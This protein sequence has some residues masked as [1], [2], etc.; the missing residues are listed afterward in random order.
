[1]EKSVAI[2]KQKRKKIEDAFGSEPTWD[3]EPDANKLRNA[4]NWYN[5]HHGRDGGYTFLKQY[6]KDT[7]YP[8][9]DHVK[10]IP[11][12][13]ISTTVFWISKLLTR[14]LPL[15][16]E[17]VDWFEAQVKELQNIEV[18]KRESVVEKNKPSVQD[19]MRELSHELIGELEEEIDKFVGDGFKSDF[20]TYTWLKVKEVGAP[21]VVKIIS[22]YEPLLQEIKDVLAKKDNALVEAYS[23]MSKDKIKAYEKFIQSIVEGN[24]TYQENKK[25]VRKTRKKKVK[26]ADQ[27][28]SKVQYLKEHS[29]LQLV[30]LPPEKI[31]GASELW[32]YNVQNRTL[33]Y[34]KAKPSHDLSIKGTTVQNFDTENSELKKVRKPEETLPLLKGKRACHDEFK[35]LTTKATSARGRIDKNTVLLK[36]F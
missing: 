5:Y 14:G 36:V 25:K 24:R 29:E 26:K 8:H 13:K 12:W 10:R 6:L 34:Y 32:A 18:Q 3:S 17:T 15:S 9:L 16:Q 27:I 19:H 28:V 2:R 30:S 31:L 33:A 7:N 11:S 4:Y 23:N 22:Y 20:D 35:A 21:L 1:M